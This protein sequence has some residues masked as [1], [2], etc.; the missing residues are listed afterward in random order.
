MKIKTKEVGKIMAIEDRD[1]TIIKWTKDVVLDVIKFDKTGEDHDPADDK[2]FKQGEHT[3]VKN[4]EEF[5][6]ESVE[7]DFMDGTSCLYISKDSFSVPLMIRLNQ[8]ETDITLN[9]VP[10]WVS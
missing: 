3:L 5:D 6:K 8:E 9:N 7:L 1:C 4:L 2:V 10:E